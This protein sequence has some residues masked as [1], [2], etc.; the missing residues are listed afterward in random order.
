[1]VDEALKDFRF[2]ASDRGWR[3][4]GKYRWWLVAQ[5]ATAMTAGRHF[6]PEVAEKR[7]VEAIGRKGVV[8]HLLKSLKVGL[9]PTMK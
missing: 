1:M 3:I 8:D 2:G 4:A 6:F 7:L 9:F 5:T